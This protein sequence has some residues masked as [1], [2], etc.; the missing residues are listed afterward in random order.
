[1]ELNKINLK[2]QVFIYAN[3]FRSETLFFRYTNCMILFEDIWSKR[4]FLH[5][6]FN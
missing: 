3:R 2:H 6:S 5:F 4:T 1:M